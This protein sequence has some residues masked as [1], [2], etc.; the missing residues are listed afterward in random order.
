MTPETPAQTIE[1]LTKRIDEFKGDS[2][3]CPYCGHRYGPKTV[4]LAGYADALKLHVAKCAQHPMH[5]LRAALEES[6]KLQSHYAVLLNGYD[7]GERMQFANADA[8]LARLRDLKAQKK[9]AARKT[10]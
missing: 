2:I 1:R 8:W 6:V 7:G 3:V 4:D 10:K 5:E 9:S